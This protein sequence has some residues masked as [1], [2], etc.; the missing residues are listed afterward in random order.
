[1]QAAA[2]IALALGAA[3]A[4]GA[5]QPATAPHVS[6]SAKLKSEARVSEDSARTVALAQVPNGVIKSGEIEREQG[7][8][9]YSFD[10]KVAGQSG[11]EEVNVDALTG[12]VLAHEHETSKAERAEAKQE[13]A[14]KKKAKRS[15][16]PAAKPPMTSTP[17]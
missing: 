2:V 8:L 7:K 9:I 13:A 11:I 4:A 17:G 6:G 5:Q 15:T 12:A 16:K 3:H 14:E 1:M 10:I